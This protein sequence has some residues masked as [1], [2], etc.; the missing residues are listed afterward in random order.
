[1][2]TTTDTATEAAMLER[3]RAMTRALATA[4]LPEADPVV[5]DELRALEELVCAAQGR[6]AALAAALPEDRSTASQV[7]LARRE[8]PHRGRQHLGLARILP[9]ELP[10]TYAAF[11]AG[12]I[13]Q[14]R[15]TLL[16]RE[17]G[18]LSLDDR[19]RI[20][21]ELAGD[22]EA[23]EAMGDREIADAARARACQL[24]P[25]SVAARRRK[26][27]TER[28][29]TIRPAPDTM[30]YL[31]ALLPVKAGVAAY[32]ALTHAADSARATGDPRTRGQV[33]ADTLTTALTTPTTSPADQTTSPANHTPEP[34]TRTSTEPATDQAADTVAPGTQPGMPVL[35]HLVMT[36]RSLFGGVEDPAWIQGYGPVPAEIG[37]ELAVQERAWL[38]RVFADPQTGELV[39]TDSRS[40]FFR[41]GLGGLIRLRD[42]ICRTPWCDAPVRHVDHIEDAAEDGPTSLENGDGLCE[43]CNHTKQTPGWQARPLPTAPGHTLEIT[44]PTGHHYRSRAPAAPGFTPPSR[45]EYH[46]SE[47]ILT[48]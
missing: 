15:V 24:D 18:C 33:M 4:P 47:L 30:T 20:D 6:Q 19:L 13:S 8:S 46:V 28:H 34:A 25:A 2:E 12:R 22:P 41:A 32:A 37:R 17:T 1:M 29:V 43:A 39:A 7:A 48:A 44:T 11:R 3:V 35:I 10:H 23:L 38:K 21:A 42:R 5:I 36:D 40:R 14:W 26:A 27:E 31:T 45:L 16:A 9:T